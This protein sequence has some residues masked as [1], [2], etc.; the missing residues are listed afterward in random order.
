MKVAE[1]MAHMTAEQAQA[2]VEAWVAWSTRAG[3]SVVDLGSPVGE[4]IYFSGS[5][6]AGAHSAVAGFSILQAEDEGALRRVLNG[7]PH[8]QVPG[9]SIEAH[10]L[11]PVPGM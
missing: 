5:P 9:N 3:N 2:G 8:V 4:P 11:I 1:A 6:A 7:H 10:E